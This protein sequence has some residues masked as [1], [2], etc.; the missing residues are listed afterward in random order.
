MPTNKLLSERRFIQARSDAKRRGIGWELTFEEFMDIWLSSGHW[1]ECGIYPDQYCMARLGPDIG[2]Y[3]VGNVKIITN[4]E[5]CEERIASDEW[6]ANQS[7][8]MQGNTNA[9]GGKGRTGLVWSEE[10]KQKL[11]AKQKAFQAGLTAE[12]RRERALRG[13]KQ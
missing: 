8:C 3:K 7:R 11:A 5:N 6:K 4:R 2:P 1:P 12:E 9:V 13:K 10:T